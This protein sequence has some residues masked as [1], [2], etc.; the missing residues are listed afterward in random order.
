MLTLFLSIIFY[1]ISMVLIEKHITING[2]L[3]VFIVE[4]I[5]CA[6]ILT[7]YIVTYLIVSLTGDYG[8]EWEAV[9]SGFFVLNVYA[10][11]LLLQIFKKQ[12]FRSTLLF[13]IIFLICFIVSF[14]SVPLICKL[15]MGD[16]HLLK[17]FVFSICVISFWLFKEMPNSITVFIC[18]II[19]IISLIPAIVLSFLNEWLFAIQFFCL[20][21]LLLAV[22]ITKRMEKLIKYKCVC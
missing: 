17:I 22:V 13:S 11:L 12:I 7:T 15:E 14:I 6:I 3:K 10:I 8:F 20:T 4:H 2:D 16:N 19:S 5:I 18:V 9:V 1:T 21:T